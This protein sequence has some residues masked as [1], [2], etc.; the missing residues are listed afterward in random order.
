M[1]VPSKLM[2]TL[3]Y[4]SQRAQVCCLCGSSGLGERAESSAVRIRSRISA[5]ALLVNVIA[6]MASGL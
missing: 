1:Y 6:R 4:A 5:A 3:E 2:V